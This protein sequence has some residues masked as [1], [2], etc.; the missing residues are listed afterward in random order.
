MIWKAIESGGYQLVRLV[1]SIVLA[2]IL[3]PANYTTLALLLIFVNLADVFVKRGFSTALIQK[4]DADNVDF[5]SVLWAS[6]AIAGVLYLVLFFTAP[7]IA[8][9]YE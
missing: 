8:A 6:L 2:R 1:I 7:A 5:S 4:K 9:F 3:D